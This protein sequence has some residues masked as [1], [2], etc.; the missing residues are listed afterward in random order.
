MLVYVNPGEDKD[1]VNGKRSSS[2]ENVKDT[3]NSDA[4]PNL[5]KKSPSPIKKF[6]DK[7]LYQSDQL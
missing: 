3:D 5:Q 7:V 6:V 2:V 4:V 1:K